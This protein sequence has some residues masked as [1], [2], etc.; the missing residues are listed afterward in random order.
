M[1][2]SWWK[3]GIAAISLCAPTG[4]DI[5]LASSAEGARCSGRCWDQVEKR[6]SGGVINL[7][8]LGLTDFPGESK[9]G[10]PLR[11]MPVHL[12]LTDP[13]SCSSASQKSSLLSWLPL[14]FSHLL[15]F[16]PQ[17]PL[18][19]P[20]RRTQLKVPSISLRNSWDLRASGPQIDVNKKAI[21][22]LHSLRLPRTN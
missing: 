20:V 14:C 7:G 4:M 5:D 10:L 6:M 18:F 11:R 3:S 2:H 15:L 9:L 17:V 13:P 21:R 1:L 22:G 19:L 16:S 12:P 8:I